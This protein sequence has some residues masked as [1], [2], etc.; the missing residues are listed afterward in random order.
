MRFAPVPALATGDAV[1][2]VAPSGPFERATFERGLER[3][4]ARYRV[5]LGAHLF[6]SRRY[7]AGDDAA[8]W[9]DFAWPRR[10]TRPRSCSSR[11]TTWRSSG[12]MWAYATVVLAE[13][14]LRQAA[15]E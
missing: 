6:E 3:L 15:R 2:V 11:L 7:L 10:Y 9:S 13:R 4:S 8:R 12:F 14:R 5:E 1:A